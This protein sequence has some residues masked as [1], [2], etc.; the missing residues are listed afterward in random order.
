MIT[1]SDLID[2]IH[3][4]RIR[5]REERERAVTL[6]QSVKNEPA[7]PN[8]AIAECFISQATEIDALVERLNT[9]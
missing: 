2:I 9:S 3:I 7:H 6:V 1:P 4:L 5:A 8:H